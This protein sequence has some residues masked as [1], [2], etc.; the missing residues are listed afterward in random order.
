MSHSGTVR[1]ITAALAAVAAL[2]SLTCAQ[3]ATLTFEY[4]FSFGSEPA[5]GP[6]PWMT[7]V[8]DDGGSPGSVTLI[9]TVAAT[10]SAADVTQI[11][12]NLDPILNPDNVTITRVSGT[13]PLS[14]ETVISKAVDSFKADGDGFFDILFD[15]DTGGQAARFNAGETLEYEFTD[16]AGTLI[17]DDF[18]FL[19]APSGGQGSFLTA[20]HVQDTGPDEEG[21]DWIA[22]SIVPVPA[23][24]WLFGSALGL[25]GWMKRRQ[26]A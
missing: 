21:S 2:L 3:A 12:F 4:D 6:T 1:G 5:D 26:T 14:S 9:V 18:N 23:A 20:A 19:S 13:G 8:F 17:A 24:F 11:Y 15:F 7:A 10:I 22:P 25:L 16:L